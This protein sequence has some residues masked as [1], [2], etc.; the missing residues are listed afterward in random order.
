MSHGAQA[1][2]LR[3]R[4]GHHAH[5]VNHSLKLMGESHCQDTRVE[6]ALAESVDPVNLNA[7]SD[8]SGIN[9]DMFALQAL[10]DTIREII[11]GNVQ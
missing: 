2:H 7:W 11:G 4:S 6:W 1:L 8:C 5:T 9:F 3:R 10:S